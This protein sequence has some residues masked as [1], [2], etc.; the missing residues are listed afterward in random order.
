[1]LHARAHPLKGHGDMID[2]DDD[3]RS[4]LQKERLTEK[5]G[6][7]FFERVFVCFAYTKNMWIK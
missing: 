1:M 6:L 2:D 7:N 3:C 5:N 4:R